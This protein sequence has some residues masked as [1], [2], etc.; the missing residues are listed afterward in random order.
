MSHEILGRGALLGAVFLSACAVGPD[1]KAP[2]APEAERYTGQPLPAQTVAAPLQGGEAQRFL[3]GRD[4]S[5][6]WWTA[7]GSP[8]IDALVDAALQNNPGVASAQ[9]ALRK[10]Q[11]DLRA[12]SATLFPALDLSATG[13]RQKVDPASFGNPN[14]GTTIYNLY[15]VSAKLSYGLDIWGGTRRGVESSRALAEAKVWEAEA[16]YQTLVANVVTAA[17]TEAEQNTLA[18]GQRLVISDQ[19]KRLAISE[20]DFANGAISRNELLALQSGLADEQAKLPPYELAM[21]QARNLLATYVGRLPSEQAS[22]GLTLDDLHLPQDLPLTVPATLVRQ[23]PDVRAA[24]AQLHSAAAQIGVATANLLPSIS[25]TA[26]IGSQASSLDKLFEGDIFSLGASITQPLFHAG[27]LTAKR[28]AAI[29]TY[30][31]SLA[32]YR[33]TVLTAFREVAD[34]LNALESDAVKLKAQF[35][36][37]QAS[38][39]MLRLTQAQF[40]AGSGTRDDVIAAQQAY[41]RARA[42]Y[43]FSIADRLRETAELFRALGGGWQNVEAA[44]PAASAAG[45]P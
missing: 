31:Q 30:D 32:D 34:A 1:F 13:T 37:A 27:E 24:E 16:T 40:D 36:Y 35:D 45:A 11:E 19:Q 3:S 14:A 28:R 6:R 8:T 29:A 20:R 44:A 9:A 42:G 23:R 2:A 15:N 17:V 41:T 12:Q 38:G 7:F 33:T 5:G 21:N 10:A 22:S 18:I 26:S 43:M 25:L 39:A 4:S